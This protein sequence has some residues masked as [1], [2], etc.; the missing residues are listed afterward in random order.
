MKSSKL[1]IMALIVILLIAGLAGLLYSTSLDKHNKEDMQTFTHGTATMPGYIGAEVY[2]DVEPVDVALTS[3]SG[4]VYMRDYVS[5][6]SIDPETKTITIL[7]DSDELGEWKITMNTKDNTSVEFKFVN[8]TSPTLYLTNAAITKE[9]DGRFYIK[10]CPIMTVTTDETVY[11]NITL[12]REGYSAPLTDGTCVTRLNDTSYILLNPPANAY[13]GREYTIRLSIQSADK[14][15]S[16]HK[17]L[18]IRLAPAE[19]IPQS[20]TP[21]QETTDEFDGGVG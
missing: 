17:D 2:Y 21:S 13:D 11:Y 4:K 18:K 19:A 1:V 3:P 16:R 14:T 6:Y 20:E 10:F 5:V 12:N 15:Q 8:T 7:H 9:D